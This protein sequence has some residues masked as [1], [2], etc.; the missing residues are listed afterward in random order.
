MQIL[1]LI[2]PEEMLIFVLRIDVQK[3]RR[4]L[5]RSIGVAAKVGKRR[6]WSCFSA[7]STETPY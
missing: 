1:V 6:V 7:K 4:A 5:K 3:Q 2:N